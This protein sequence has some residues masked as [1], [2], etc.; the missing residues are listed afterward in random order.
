[1]NEIP[2]LVSGHKAICRT[3]ASIAKAQLLVEGE[4]SRSYRQITPFSKPFNGFQNKI[5]GLCGL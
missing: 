4:L 5:H 1:V 2:E 3:A